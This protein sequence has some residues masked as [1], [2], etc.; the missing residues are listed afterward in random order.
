MNY[1]WIISLFIICHFSAKGQIFQNSGALSTSMSGLN[2]NN[3]DIWSVNN[4]ISQLSKIKKPELSI[5]SFQPFLIKD[6]TTSSIVFGLPTK[7]GAFGMNFST[8]GNKHL[9][10]HNVGFGYSQKLGENIQSGIKLNYFM[11][12]AGDYYNKKSII[13]ADI[14][15]SSKLSNELQ[16]GVCI[17]NPTFTKLSNFDDERLATNIQLAAGYKFSNELTLHTGV[18][19]SIFYPASFLAAIE[20]QPSEKIFLS[21]GIKSNPSIASF[22]I[23]MSQKQFTICAASQIHQFLGWSPDLSIIYQFK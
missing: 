4:N 10:M 17:K 11:I 18:E 9:Q 7:K 23:S 3:E 12:N 20:Y 16:L 5:S 19:K 14:G 15:F 2:V 1:N 21:G 6:F 22:G 13:S 8:N